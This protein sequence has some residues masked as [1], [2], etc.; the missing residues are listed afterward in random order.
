M[1]IFV[2]C[3]NNL[4]FIIFPK[5]IYPRIFV[6]DNIVLRLIN[7]GTIIPIPYILKKKSLHISYVY[8]P[9]THDIGYHDGGVMVT[10]QVSLEQLRK[11]SEL[12]PI[13]SNWERKKKR[14]IIT[15]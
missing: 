11:S 7:Q 3:R 8:L 14:V 9:I 10:K 1:K 5:N 4:G 6:F 2:L 12:D 15:E 13:N